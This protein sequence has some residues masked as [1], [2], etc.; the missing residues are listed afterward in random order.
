MSLEGTL[1]GI[2]SAAAL[3]FTAWALALITLPQVGVVVVAAS[4]G[5][6]IESAL[7]ATLEGRGV[8]NND[9]LNFINTGTAAFV[10]VTLAQ[11]L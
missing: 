6:L 9:V 5:A 3:A 7:G 1:A 2:G 10:A 8:V 11:S 4:V